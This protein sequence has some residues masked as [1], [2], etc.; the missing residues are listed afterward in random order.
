MAFRIFRFCA[1]AL[2]IGLAV[3]PGA[4][5]TLTRRATAN[6]LPGF[7]TSLVRKPHVTSRL[8]HKGRSKLTVPL[9]APPGCTSN[10]QYSFV[11]GGLNNFAGGGTGPNSFYAASLEGDGNEACDEST[12][13]V[14]GFAN[15]IGGDGSTVGTIIGGG[16]QNTVESASYAFVGGGA[17]N[18]MA[19]QPNVLGVSNANYSGIASGQQ[20]TITGPDSF[21]GGGSGNTVLASGGSALGE[22]AFIGAGTSNLVGGPD[23]DV[24]SG[25]ANNVSAGSSSIVG[26]AY[27]TIQAGGTEGLAASSLSFIGGG[28]SNFIGSSESPAAAGYNVITGGESNTIHGTVGGY[29]AF[30]VISGGYEN[31]IGS[32]AGGISGIG[33]YSTI[34]GGFENTV[35][36]TYATVS[37]GNNN[38]ALGTGT[39]ISG[40]STNSATGTD[41]IVSGGANN[42]TSGQSSS[43]SGG[44]GTTVAG[45]YAG[46]LAGQ[47]NSVAANNSATIAGLKNTVSS[48]AQYSTI[49]GGSTNTISG[50]FSSI[51]GGYSNK[52]SGSYSVVSGGHAN[53]ASG[54]TST[55]AGGY[56]NVA[57]GQ[58]A[59]AVGGGFNVASGRD[60]FAA[61]YESHAVN[62][63]SFVWT[64]YESSGNVVTSSAN[65]QFLARASGGFF[66]YSS[67]NLT[68]GVTLAPGSGSWSSLSDRAAKTSI[69]DVD[70][71]RILA[72]VARLPVSEWSYS[73]QGTRVR[74]IG[75]MAQ[76]FRTAFGLGE[77]DRH[78]STI[79]EEGVALSAIKALKAEL[80]DKE[81]QI[82]ELRSHG[83]QSDERLGSLERRLGALE[84]AH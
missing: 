74:H 20:N 33:Y 28:A 29:S 52:V 70:N 76:D 58:N 71:S 77:D 41:S 13:I 32:N 22:N 75:P 49:T 68:S 6:S 27:N 60:S 3:A 63:G 25:V 45:S 31:F 35:N 26:G 80:S 14:D 15:V 57:S 69:Q 47:S 38:T 24:V 79:D 37:G 36:G 51:G 39:T 61:G 81:R 54:V 83:Q 55:V 56:S 5:T 48:T 59:V 67:A 21:V 66:L 12:G 18:V 7:P 64:D 50:E 2:V 62:D 42:T 30:N 82:A 34:G 53:T 43:I 4:A 40:G 44:A 17:G 10:G 1:S 84:A 72:K 78:I 16:S 8:I 65:G 11:G 73:A 23:S 19:V 46:S 9:V